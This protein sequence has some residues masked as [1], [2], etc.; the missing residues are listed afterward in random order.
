MKKEIKELEVVD[1]IVRCAKAKAYL[2]KKQTMRNVK[3]YNDRNTKRLFMFAG[4][5]VPLALSMNGIANVD[6][7]NFGWVILMYIASICMGYIGAMQS[8]DKPEK[9]EIEQ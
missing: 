8:L 7:V 5:L 1:E 9:V 3:E 2:I 6:G 4:C